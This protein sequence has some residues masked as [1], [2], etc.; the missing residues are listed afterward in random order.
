MGDLMGKENYWGLAN[1]Y[2]LEMGWGPREPGPLNLVPGD[3]GKG[4]NAFGVPL[5]GFS[6]R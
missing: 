5:S 2:T 3:A 1:P 6:H 4:K